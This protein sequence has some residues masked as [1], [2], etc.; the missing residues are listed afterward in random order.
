MK[1]M[2]VMLCAVL[3]FG[4]DIAQ[5]HDWLSGT[6]KGV[7]RLECVSQPNFRQRQALNSPG[8]DTV[9]QL[10]YNPT[11]KALT[12]HGEAH[13][14]RIATSTFTETVLEGS[15]FDGDTGVLMLKQ[16]GGLTDG[17]VRTYVLE[18]RRDG[19]LY[20]YDDEPK[21]RVTL[22]LHKQ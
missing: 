9:L 1:P 11:T 2:I 6:W 10:Q 21:T 7:R 18:R 19:G 22:T 5:E 13:H 16:S 20:G 14:L 8:A 3:W 17:A 12:G 15:Y 4:V